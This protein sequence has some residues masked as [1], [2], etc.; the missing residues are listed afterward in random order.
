[1]AKTRVLLIGF[2]ALLL[3][4]LPL[5]GACTKEVVKEVPVEKIVEKEV[6][7][8]VAV[9]K[10]APVKISQEFGLTGPYAPQHKHIFRAYQ[11]YIRYIN[12]VDGG[13]PDTEGVLHPVEL[14]WGD[15]QMK[16]PVSI[17]LYDKAKAAG[18]L[19]HGT[20]WVAA[21]AAV[22]PKSNKDKM[23]VFNLSASNMAIVP[24]GYGYILLPYYEDI[25]G[26]YVDWFLESWDKPNPSL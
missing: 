26:A 23:P 6:I 7:K 11:D 3:I 10:G 2:L 1:M 19:V 14:I 16:A 8:E 21:T 9:K 4:T 18:A 12:E 22:K 15:M 25:V 24:Q 17:S 13:L 20:V 5:L